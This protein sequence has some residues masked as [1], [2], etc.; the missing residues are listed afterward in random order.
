[1]SDAELKPSCEWCNKSFF[2]IYALKRHYDRCKSKE[3]Y[4]SK[5]L[6]KQLREL[7]GKLKESDYK[8]KELEKELACEKERN[9]MVL[10]Q[11]ESI[12]QE[13]KNIS[14]KYVQEKDKYTELYVKYKQLETKCDCQSETLLKYEKQ[15]GILLDKMSTSTYNN[16]VAGFGEEIRV[17]H[18][19]ILPK[20][21]QLITDTASMLTK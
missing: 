15:L 8:Q 21:Q 17:V 19:D 6:D 18:N 4:D 1:M 11:K 2:N 12:Q 3:E 10:S 20:C 14:E 16:I 9:Q 13:Y 5:Q 7:N